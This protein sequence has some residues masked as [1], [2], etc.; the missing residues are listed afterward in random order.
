MGRSDGTT[1]VE[2][3]VVGMPYNENGRKRR[4]MSLVGGTFST[5]A[6]RE[7]VDMVPSSLSVMRGQT[8]AGRISRTFDITSH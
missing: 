2:F 7:E 8:V 6:Q 5:R 4:L 3:P 1:E